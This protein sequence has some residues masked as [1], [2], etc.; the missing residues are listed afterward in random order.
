MLDKAI[1]VFHDLMN[2][3]KKERN[4]RR[5]NDLIS[6]LG[7]HKERHLTAYKENNC[8]FPF[9]SPFFSQEHNLHRE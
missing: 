7:E 9:P 4:V 6:P 8:S 5:E 3:I 1:K 2:D